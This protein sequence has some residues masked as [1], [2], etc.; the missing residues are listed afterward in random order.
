MARRGAISARASMEPSKKELKE[1]LCPQEKQEEDLFIFEEGSKNG[2]GITFA[3]EFQ[4]KRCWKGMRFL[5]DKN[6]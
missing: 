1:E 3:E 2:V 5:N 6:M 4:E